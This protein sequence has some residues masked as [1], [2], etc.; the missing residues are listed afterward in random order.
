MRKSVEKRSVLGWNKSYNTLFW[1]W[2]TEYISGLS[3]PDADSGKN[4]KFWFGVYLDEWLWDSENVDIWEEVRLTASH[5]WILISHLLIKAQRTFFHS[6][7]LS[8]NISLRW[9]TV[10]LTLDNTTSL[11]FHRISP[12]VNIHLSML[13][14][15]VILFVCYRP[16]QRV[17]IHW[18]LR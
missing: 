17:Q 5:K 15:T 16:L 7:T 3:P 10:C 1:H 12:T 9:G 14:V 11:F 6:L 4:T 13:I 18:R 2:P 8:Q